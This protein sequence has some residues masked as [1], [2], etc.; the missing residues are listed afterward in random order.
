MTKPEG[1]KETPK[2]PPRPGNL[3]LRAPHV[4]SQSLVKV[5]LDFTDAETAAQT[6]REMAAASRLYRG[7]TF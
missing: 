3:P 7:W 6:A 5:L 2:S 1:L 4:S